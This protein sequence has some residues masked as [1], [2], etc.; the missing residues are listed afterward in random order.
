MTKIKFIEKCKLTHNIQY[1]YS[2]IPEEFKTQEKP[3]LEIGCPICNSFFRVRYDQF[4]AGSNC[5]CLPAGRKIDYTNFEKIKQL[6]PNLDFSNSV[7][8]GITNNLIFCCKEHG[9]QTLKAESL[10]RETS[11]CPVCNRNKQKLSV[12][13]LKEKL[14]FENFDYELDKPFYTAK[15]SLI[16]TCK[17]CGLIFKQNSRVHI[18]AKVSYRHS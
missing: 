2:K 9:Y 4:Q 15:D 1:D 5:P 7:Y 17:N 13:E 12:E 6:H 8:T 18:H 10:L 14:D 11:D 16:I 3:Y